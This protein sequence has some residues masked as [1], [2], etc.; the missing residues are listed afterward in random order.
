MRP[1]THRARLCPSQVEEIVKEQ[2]GLSQVMTSL[3]G[4]LEE[5]NVQLYLAG[6]TILGKVDHTQ[7]VF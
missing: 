6:V 4:L 5:T 7:S 1:A 3:I 2:L